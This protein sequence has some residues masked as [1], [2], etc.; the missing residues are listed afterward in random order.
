MIL[1]HKQG[2]N[3]LKLEWLYEFKFRAL[4]KKLFNSV[5][6]NLLCIGLFNSKDAY[7]LGKSASGTGTS[8]SVSTR[9]DQWNPETLS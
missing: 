8:N 4:L 2:D 1:I 9:L 3:N 6:C 5:G 7:A